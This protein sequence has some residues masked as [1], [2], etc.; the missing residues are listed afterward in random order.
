MMCGLDVS[1]GLDECSIFNVYV[2]DC[3]GDC[4]DEVTFSRDYVAKSRVEEHGVERQV[5]GAP[6][7]V[8]D[9]TCMS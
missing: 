9:E 2:N 7:E 1:D 6:G 8:T 5:F 3:E 4:A